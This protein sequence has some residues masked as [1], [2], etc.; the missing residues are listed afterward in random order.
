MFGREDIQAMAK[1]QD[2]DAGDG[3]NRLVS[4]FWQLQG[5][6]HHAEPE[7]ADRARQEETVLIDS[8]PQGEG[9]DDHCERQAHFMDDWPAQ[10]S[11]C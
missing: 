1:C 4:T 9:S 3:V 6:R 11:P 2:H 5:A 7:G 10:Q 8:A